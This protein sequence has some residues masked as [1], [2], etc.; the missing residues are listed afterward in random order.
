MSTPTEPVAPVAPV[1]PTQTRYPWRAT[2]RTA[3]AVLVALATLIPLVV[4]DAPMGA[5]GG[6]LVVVAGVITR[7][8]AMPAVNDF[9]TRYAGWLAPAPPKV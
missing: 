7:I 1:A 3:F 6:Q 8:L 2:T 4:A 9:I 5:L